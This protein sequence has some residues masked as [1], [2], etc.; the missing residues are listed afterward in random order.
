MID[1]LT[2]VF[3]ITIISVSGASPIGRCV[4]SAPWQRN[5]VG[6]YHRH[7]MACD[8]RGDRHPPCGPR[9]NDTDVGVEPSRTK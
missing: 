4:G 9:I 6:E 8:D 7:D 5:D 2:A 1:R 3:Y